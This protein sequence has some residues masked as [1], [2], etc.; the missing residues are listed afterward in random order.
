MSYLVATF[1]QFVA[2]SDYRQKQPE[3]QKYCQERGIK[4]TILLAAE[5]INAT[6]A[7]T[8]QAIA[9]VISWLK[10]DT[11]LANL[12]VKESVCD[13][14]PFQRLK[15][16][17]KQEIVT[18]GQPK[19][20]PLENTGIH[21]KTEEWNQLLKEPDV[22]V[23]DTRNNYEV[24]I[25][26]FAGALNPEIQHFRQFPEYIQEN[27]DS[28]N[29]KKIALFCTGGI[30]CE[31]AA[32][33]LLNQGFSQVYQLEGGILKYLEEVSPDQSLW[34]GE[35]F[36]FDQRVALTANLEV[37]HYE[38]CPACGHPI[39]EKDKQSPNYR[40]GISCPYCS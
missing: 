30:R 12:E 35:C 37:G 1:Y 17:L 32:A 9:E 21:L 4:G 6:I 7:G 15:I 26:T 5:G 36:V 39:D 28:I 16:R 25:G 29:D 40:A 2:L 3:I 23:I 38:M 11:R 14:L 18:F 20:N 24:V 10:T 19:A 31:K 13:Y 34:Q 27:F 22:V 33:F 8:R